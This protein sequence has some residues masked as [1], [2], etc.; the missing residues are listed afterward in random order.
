MTLLDEVENYFGTRNLYEAIGASKNSTES[1]IKKAYRKASLKCHPDRVSEDEK[2][3]STK[4]FQALA[5]IHF[6]LANEERKKLYD[7]HGIVA[8]EDG[9]ESEADWSSYWRLLFPKVSSKEINNFMDQY[10][11]SEEETADLIKI[12]ERTKGD[13]DKIYQIHMSFDEERTSEQ[14]RKLIDEGKV[15]AYDKFTKEPKAKKD[16]RMRRCER[17]AVRAEKFKKEKDS[18][19]LENA[20]SLVAMIQS[21]RQVGFDSMISKLEQKYANPSAN[22]GTKRKRSNR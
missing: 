11:G 8:N 17:E 4:K 7:D 20:D 19:E 1:E 2:A 6:I 10:V 16:K 9:L 13:M 22:K 21:R 5:Q 15:E 3:E 18:A 14:I 12:Y